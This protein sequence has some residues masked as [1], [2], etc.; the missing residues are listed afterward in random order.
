MREV[1]SENEVP[2]FQI[3]EAVWWVTER[4]QGWPRKVS[5]SG[6]GLC[7][8]MA[9]EGEQKWRRSLAMRRLRNSF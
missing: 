8:G 7:P 3:L 5:R 4:S 2:D 9:V 1:V 6:G